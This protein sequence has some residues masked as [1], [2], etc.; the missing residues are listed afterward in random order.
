MK[1]YSTVKSL[2]L[3]LASLIVAVVLEWLQ[4][5]VIE[6]SAEILDPVLDVF[7]F[8]SFLCYMFAFSLGAL[9]SPALSLPFALATAFLLGRQDC[10][11][12]YTVLPGASIMPSWTLG[13]F[14][15]VMGRI[16]KRVTGRRVRATA[17]RDEDGRVYVRHHPI[18]EVAA[19]FRPRLW[20]IV[21]SAAAT[22]LV[23]AEP[24]H[25]LSTLMGWRS[26]NVV[27]SLKESLFSRRQHEARGDEAETPW[28]FLNDF[29]KDRHQDGHQGEAR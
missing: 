2:A 21:F 26:R 22:M 13:S 28:D 19:Q 18:A 27:Q 7:N 12:S 10:W 9:R 14:S 3:P 15:H 20:A 24:A 23:L 6:R 29:L 8:A 1:R 5:V 4:H 17:I 11:M 25:T 16:I